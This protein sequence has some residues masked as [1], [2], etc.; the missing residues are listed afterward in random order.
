MVLIPTFN[1]KLKQ[2]E[3]NKNTT[4]SYKKKPD[5]LCNFHKNF[6]AMVIFVKTFNLATEQ[7]LP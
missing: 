1:Y 6:F 7:K 5:L 3:H 2:V 4:I